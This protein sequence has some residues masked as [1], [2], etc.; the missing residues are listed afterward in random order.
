MPWNDQPCPIALDS[1]DLPPPPYLVYLDVWERLVTTL[2]DD[3][4]R[5][6][7]ATAIN[8]ALTLASR[9]VSFA[10]RSGCA[11]AQQPRLCA[12]R[13][14]EHQAT[15]AICPLCRGLPPR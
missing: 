2:D 5:D 12:R 8:D 3:A 11:A 10:V 7:A 14:N 6:V 15:P 4:L 9:L 1:V 13:R